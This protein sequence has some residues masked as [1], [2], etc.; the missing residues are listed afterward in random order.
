[1]G[2]L[3]ADKSAPGLTDLAHEDMSDSIKVNCTGAWH[4]VANVGAELQN[5]IQPEH[6]ASSTFRAEC[7]EACALRELELVKHMHRTGSTQVNLWCVTR[8]DV[9]AYIAALLGC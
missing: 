9:P 2:E 3:F 8:D 4:D 1:L 6:M 5:H 7:A